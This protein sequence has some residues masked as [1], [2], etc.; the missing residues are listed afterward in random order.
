MPD[1]AP[2]RSRL[3]LVRSALWGLVL[4]VSAVLLY[5]WVFGVG[6]ID[7]SYT[8]ATEPYGTDF[9]LVD[10][11]GAAF[12]QDD[13]RGHPTAIFFGFT[14]C[15]DICPTTLYELAG[16]REA[17]QEEGKDIEVVFVTVDPERDTPEILSQYVGSLGTEVTALSGEPEA[18]RSMLEGWGIHSRRV[19]EGDNYTMDHTASVI[20]LGAA[21]QFVGT[22]A[23]GENPQTA[24]EKLERLVTL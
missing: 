12:T 19:G 22:I 8:A 3:P 2:S 5:V 6:R 18:V 14:H 24:R 4:I 23:Y 11:T 7:G 10:Q 16:H 21:G 1:P 17:L 9:A 15:P 13:L 20:L